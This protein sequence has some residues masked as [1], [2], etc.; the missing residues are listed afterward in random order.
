MDL[1]LTF[2]D[3]AMNYDTI[4]PTYP[5]ELFEDI[6][7][8]SDLSSNSKALE[9]GIGTGQATLPFL[10][11]NINVTGIDIG[12][13]LCEFVKEKFKD[14]SN[15]DIINNDFTENEFE[16]NHFDLIYCATA[17][18]WLPEN[19]LDK[20]KSILKDNG[21]IALFWNHP[22]PNRMDDESNRINR[23]IYSKYRPN[24]KEQIEF[25]EKDC[26]KK[27]SQLKLF[28]Y[29]NIECKLYHGVRTLTSNEYIRLLNTYSDHIAMPNEIKKQFD[30][31]MKNSLDKIGGTINIY[32]TID[33]YLAK[34]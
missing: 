33:L 1:K 31:D 2:N 16:E 3:N 5:S 11:K 9:I 8:Y 28:G 25:T 30:N 27:I 19:A 21:T 18:H 10:N 32:D 26:D 17:F 24:D 7:A 15:F 20:C 29:K 13:N 12:N 4:R 23:E 34:K 6:W 14:Y 22:Y